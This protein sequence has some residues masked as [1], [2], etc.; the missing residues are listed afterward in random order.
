MVEITTEEGGIII[1]EETLDP[2]LDQIVVEEIETDIMIDLMEVERD[3]PRHTTKKVKVKIAE[4]V[5]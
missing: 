4:V 5:E 2:D 3:N 1:T